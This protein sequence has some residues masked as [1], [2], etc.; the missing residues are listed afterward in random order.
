MLRFY[1][2]D[3]Y[4]ALEIG[5][6][7]EPQL[8]GHHDSVYH[9]HEY[10]RDFSSRTTRLFSSDDIAKFGKYLTKKGHLK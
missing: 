7:P 4:L 8:T 3:K 6:H 5:F 2:K 1:D 9:I 10:G